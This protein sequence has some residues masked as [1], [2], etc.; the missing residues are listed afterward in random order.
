MYLRARAGLG[1]SA[2]GEWSGALAPASQYG[3]A[4]P[5]SMGLETFKRSEWHRHRD[6]S[7]NIV[8]LKWIPEI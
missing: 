3:C 5:I 1:D 7:Q 6:Q 4:G 2:N 8:S